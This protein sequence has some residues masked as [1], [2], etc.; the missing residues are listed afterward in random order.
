MPSPPLHNHIKVQV[1]AQVASL[2]QSWWHA[3]GAPQ[4]H[5]STWNN[6]QHTE[7]PEALSMVGCW[8]APPGE[9]TSGPP[10]LSHMTWHKLRAME[11]HGTTQGHR[12]VPPPQAGDPQT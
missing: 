12:A 9:G 6:Y 3:P 2:K 1:L 8:G 5:P 11:S 10:G 4:E 7:L